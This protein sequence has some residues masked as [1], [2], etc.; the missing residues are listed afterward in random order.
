MYMYIAYLYCIQD[1]KTDTKLT[2]PEVA[3]A[4]FGSVLIKKKMSVKKKIP[5]FETK[6]PT[7]KFEISSCHMAALSHV[8]VLN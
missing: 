3:P 2:Y 6:S 5:S 4:L 7:E 8:L 1:T